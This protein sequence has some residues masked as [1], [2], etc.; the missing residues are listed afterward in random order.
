VGV[1]GI[2]YK[3]ASTFDGEKLLIRKTGV[4]LNAAVDRS[5]ALTTQVV[6][7]YKMVDLTRCEFMLDYLA[8]VLNSRFMLAYHLRTRG[9]GEWRSHPYVTQ[10]VIEELPI[11]SPVGRNRKIAEQI[12]QE[13]RARASAHSGAPDREIRIERLVSDLYQFDQADWRWA[14][15]VLDGAQALEGIKE[16]RIDVPHRLK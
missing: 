16:L 4:G 5:G 12:A 3:S 6:F 10:S 14:L 11:P 1:P 8:A 13:S 15:A 7:H 2:A 9:E